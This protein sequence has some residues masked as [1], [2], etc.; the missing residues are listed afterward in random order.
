MASILQPGLHL[1]GARAGADVRFLVVVGAYA[2][3]VQGRPR[4]TSSGVGQRGVHLLGQ[5]LQGERFLEELRA[6]L[7][8]PLFA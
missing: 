3:G 6:D 1:A 2:V 8:Q 4:A 5:R 7:A